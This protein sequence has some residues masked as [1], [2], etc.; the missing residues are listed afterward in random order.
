M[1]DGDLKFFKDRVIRD[2]IASILL[3]NSCLTHTQYETLIIDILC[4]KNS[5]IN[6]T[7]DEKALLRS[8]NVSR[9]SFSRT[10][11]QA[12]GNVVSAIYTILLLSYIGVFDEAPFDAYQ[13]LAE[14]L[15][16]YLEIF[17]DSELSQ[18]RLLL[19]RI[20]KELM[21][22]IKELAQPKSLRPV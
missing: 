5:D 20:E 11:A 22:G 6:I 3:K 12:R 8:R 15:R 17:R 2:P 14:K 1:V 13:I 10:L 18:N 9:G 21:D 7:Y 19:Q 16:D 4:N